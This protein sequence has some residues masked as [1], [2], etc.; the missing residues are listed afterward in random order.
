M[1]SVIVNVAEVAPWG[2]MTLKGTLATVGLELDSETVAPPLGAAAVR[3]TVPAPGALTY[4]LPKT[5][6]LR[7]DG[8]VGIGV[9]LVVG[10]EGP[11]GFGVGTDDAVGLMVIPKLASTVEYDAVKVTGIELLTIPVATV[12]IV[13]VDP[14]GI[15]TLE[16]M[17]A[18]AVLELLS[19]TMAPPLP[20]AA[21]RVTVPVPV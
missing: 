18:A 9:G 3:V 8:P 4:M 11:V 16:G 20:A 21:V 17:L 13:E 14:C 10:T 12:N 5:G 19:D 1:A 2:T 6:L 15:V 7:G